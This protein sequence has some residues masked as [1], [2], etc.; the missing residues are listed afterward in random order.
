[1]ICL[2]SMKETKLASI[3]LWIGLR[4][5]RFS[6]LWLRLTW[7]DCQ[8]LTALRKT[9]TLVQLGVETLAVAKGGQLEMLQRTQKRCPVL[10]RVV[11]EPCNG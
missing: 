4:E 8:A 7:L 1:M 6:L 10:W 3:R 5:D 11:V 9:S 2:T